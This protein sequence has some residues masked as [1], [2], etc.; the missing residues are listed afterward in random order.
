M[1]EGN[2][3]GEKEVGDAGGEENECSVFYDTF[4]DFGVGPRRGVETAAVHGIAFDPAFDA[5]VNVFEKHG[6]RA[7]P[8]TPDA[9]EDGRDEEEREAESGDAKEHQPRVLKREG[10]AEEVEAAG[11]YIKEHRRAAVDGYPG[12]REVK[13]DEQPAGNATQAGEASARIRRMQKQPRAVITNGGD[14][15]AVGADFWVKGQRSSE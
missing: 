11:G 2:E 5:A 12:K 8:A 3:V 1:R 9:S 10:A 13:R 14:G 7:G 4:D 15:I 6:L